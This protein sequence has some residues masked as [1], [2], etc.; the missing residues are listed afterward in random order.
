MPRRPRWRALE[1]ERPARTAIKRADHRGEYIYALS[2]DGILKLYMGTLTT[3]MSATRNS[4][5]AACPAVRSLTLSSIG[6]EG[7]LKTGEMNSG[8]VAERI[9][10]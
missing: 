10:S 9:A 2:C 7:A 3:T 6:R 5:S 4:L 1:K 8:Q